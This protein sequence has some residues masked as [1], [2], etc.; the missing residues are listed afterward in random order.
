LDLI[1][2]ILSMFSR[3]PNSDASFFLPSRD[4]SLIFLYKAFLC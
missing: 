3:T 2:E 4:S 1:A